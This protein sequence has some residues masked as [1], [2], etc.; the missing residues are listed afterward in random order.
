MDAQLPFNLD[1]ERAVIGSLFLDRDSIIA[2]APGLTPDDFY[3]P[4]HREVFAAA[5]DC[6]SRRVPCDLITVGDVLRQAG[7]LAEHGDIPG[8]AMYADAVPTAYHVQ[9]YAQIVADTALSRAMIQAGGNIASIGYEPLDRAA[10]VH[11]AQQLLE[12]ATQRQ[13]G[14][15]WVYADQISS[16]WRAS[17]ESGRSRPVSTGMIT[18]DRMLAGGLHRGELILLAAR[19]S[20]GKTSLALQ[21]TRN[22]LDTEQIAAWFSIEMDRQALWDRLVSTEARLPVEKVRNYGIPGAV[23]DREMMAIAEADGKLTELGRGRFPV[24]DSR[25][26]TITDIRNAALALQA[27]RGQVGLLVVD[28]IQLAASPGRRD[29]NRVLEIGEVSRGLRQLAGELNC[30]VLALAQ[31]RRGAGEGENKVPLLSDLR[32]SG[33]LEQDADVVLFL[34]REELYNKNS[35]KKGVVD[36]HIAKQRQGALGAVSVFFKSEY[37]RWYDVDGYSNM[38][39]Y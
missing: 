29:Q 30:P 35:Q 12:R 24:I 25:G 33:N 32:E 5:L 10:L 16:E 14:S 21:L 38:E 23:N 8:L 20:V 13:Q 2:V 39:G 7:T 4:Q 37:G 31:L 36:V 6:Y 28:Y 22:I 15:Q 27:E 19:T 34:D 9:Y 11:K 26:I 17:H 1:A 3:L 18:L